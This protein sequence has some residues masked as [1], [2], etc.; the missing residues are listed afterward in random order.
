[1][2]ASLTSAMSGRPF[3]RYPIC[4]FVW[5]TPSDFRRDASLRCIGHQRGI[6][7]GD[8]GLMMFNHSCGTTLVTEVERSHAS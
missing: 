3:K 6:S 8:S 1:M 5:A 2:G 4:H 7:A